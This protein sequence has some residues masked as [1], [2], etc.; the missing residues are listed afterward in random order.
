MLTSTATALNATERDTIG[1]QR[2]LNKPVRYADLVRAISGLLAESPSGNTGSHARFEIAEAV[3]RQNSKF[4]G[5]V[6]LVEDTPTN[7][8]VALAMLGA[9]GLQPALAEDGS[10]AIAA[11]S[12]RHFDLILMDCQMPIMDGYDATAAIRAMPGERGKT[13]IVALTANAM[14]GDEAKCLRAGMNGFLPKPFTMNQLSAVLGRWLVRSISETGTRANPMAINM[15]Q[16]TTLREIGAEVGTDL[17]AN[18]LQAFV[19]A[20][21]DYLHSIERAIE[22]RDAQKLGRAAHSMKSSAANFGADALATVYSKLE[23][24]A[25]EGSMDASQELL[26]D[27]RREHAAVVA[28]AREILEDATA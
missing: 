15:S 9:M 12:E 26:E 27:L 8:K 2:F 16:L 6:L 10:A 14:Q 23:S 4:S 18:V 20:P 7:Q 11:V 1:I 24:L 13:P 22:A 25:R 3:R 5:A 21:E 19:S 28:R 17:V